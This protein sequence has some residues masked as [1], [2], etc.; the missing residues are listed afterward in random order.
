[1]SFDLRASFLREKAPHPIE[2][3]VKEAN[4]KFAAMVN[5]QSKTVEQAVAE[6]ERRYDRLPP[7]GFDKWFQLA[8][9]AD[10]PIVDEFDTVMHTLEPFWGFSAQEFQARARMVPGDPFLAMEIKNHTVNIFHDTLVLAHFN[11]IVLEWTRRH[12]DLFPDML[13]VVNGLAEPRVI[14][15]NDRLEHLIHSCAPPAAES[16]NGTRK[17]LEVLDLGKESSWQIGMR[18][19]PE[20]SPSRALV[21]PD[22]DNSGIE[23][24]QNVTLAKDWCMHPKA[25][26]RHAMFSSPYNMKITDTMV[27]IFSHGKPSTSQDILYPSPDYLDGYRAGRYKEEED[28]PWEDKTNKLYWVGSDTGGYA[29]GNEWHEFH[30]QRFVELLS[31]GENEISLLRRDTSGGWQSYPEKMANLTDLAEVKFSSIDACSHATCHDEFKSLPVGQR[32]DPSRMHGY[33]F[34]FDVDG[35]G[36]TERYYRLLGSHSTVLKQTMHQEWH[37]DRLVPWVHYVPISLS[38]NELPET[39]RFLALTEKGQK[40][41]KDIADAGRD[42]QRRALREKDMELAFVRILLEYGRL[43]SEDRDL[44]GYCP[45]NRRRL[46]D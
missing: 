7:P 8:Q 21:I 22:E 46:E 6:Y 12:Q 29:R 2:L 34:L 24:V 30:R 37:D 38:M 20:D 32:E 36:R 14:A 3:L 9:E 1:M 26:Q 39:L 41:S 18:S 33:R 43:Y 27:P 31:N 4:Q 17:N 25:A 28:G 19:C 5:H 16:L 23:F 40:I 15:P 35:M 42:W 13:Y 11:E 10:C 45:S 44:E